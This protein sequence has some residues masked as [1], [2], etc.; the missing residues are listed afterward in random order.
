M[1]SPEEIHRVLE[2]MVGKMRLIRDGLP[3]TAEEREAAEFM[4]GQL[5]LRA[6]ELRGE[7]ARLGVGLSDLTEAAALGLAF[8]QR[9]YAKR[10]ADADH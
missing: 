9:D 4:S 1:S 10:I 6:K 7:Y 8:I 3:L 5:M 2:E